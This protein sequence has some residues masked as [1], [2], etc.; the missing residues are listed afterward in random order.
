MQVF[1]PKNEFFSGP[2]HRCCALRNAVVVQ[3]KSSQCPL[4]QRKSVNNRRIPSFPLRNTTSDFSGT[5]FPTGKLVNTTCIIQVSEPNGTQHQ[6]NTQ[7][8]ISPSTS[9][10]LFTSLPLEVGPLNTARGSG[11]CCKLPQQGLGWSLSG[12]RIWYM[13]AIKSDIWWHQFC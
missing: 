6:S 8:Q 7:C 10:H 5:I 3:L 9:S 11:Q 12:K 4:P 1:L 2:C 13:L